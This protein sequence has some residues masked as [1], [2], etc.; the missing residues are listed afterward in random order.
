M[1]VNKIGIITIMDYSNYGNR[2]QNY[3]LTYYLQKE[4]SLKVETLTIVPEYKK[5]IRI[6]LDALKKLN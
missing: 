6:G 5:R 3:A 2:L 4:F 1:S